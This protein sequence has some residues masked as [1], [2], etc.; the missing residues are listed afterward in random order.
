M[1]TARNDTATSRIVFRG[2]GAEIYIRRRYKTCGIQIKGA[3]LADRTFAIVCR[4]LWK[5]IAL[6][7]TA[8]QNGEAEVQGIARL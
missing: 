6:I 8:I 3:A 2:Y 5:D 4:T 1:C 7:K